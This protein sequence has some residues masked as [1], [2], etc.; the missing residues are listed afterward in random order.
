MI[1][2]GRSRISCAVRLLRNLADH[3]GDI[4]AEQW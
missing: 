1:F 4:S 3:A 2:S